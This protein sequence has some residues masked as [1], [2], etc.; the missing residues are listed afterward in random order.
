MLNGA[1]DGTVLIL[2]TDVISEV[3]GRQV[4]NPVPL[5]LLRFYIGW[6]GYWFTLIVKTDDSSD[7]LA[8]A[9]RII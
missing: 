3:R 5:K 1:V 2:P 4:K 9:S 6:T 7:A 8:R